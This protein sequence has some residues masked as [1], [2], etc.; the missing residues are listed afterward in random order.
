MI[1]K[2]RTVSY[3]A[4]DE[5]RGNAGEDGTL[6]GTH[7]AGSVNEI[8]LSEERGGFAEESG[9][10]AASGH[11]EPLQQRYIPAVHVNTQ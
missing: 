7:Q 11:G 9:N 10:P 5:C 8:V 3:G 2:W 6:T 1:T 4:A